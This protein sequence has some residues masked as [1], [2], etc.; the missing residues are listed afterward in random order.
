MPLGDA[1]CDCTTHPSSKPLFIA[2]LPAFAF[3][4]P[5]CVVLELFFWFL[6]LFSAAVVVP[7]VEEGACL[8]GNRGFRKF[9]RGFRT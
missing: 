6:A 3:L 5:F 4:F 9:K 1:Q 8:P 7:A 2:V